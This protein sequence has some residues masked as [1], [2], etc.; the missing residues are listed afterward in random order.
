MQNGKLFLIQLRSNEQKR[1]SG[2]YSFNVM[3]QVP[4]RA[5]RETD[6]MTT[7][8]TSMPK[9]TS[10]KAQV[11]I[12]GIIRHVVKPGKTGIFTPVPEPLNDET[13]LQVVLRDD[14]VDLWKFTNIPIGKISTDRNLAVYSNIDGASFIVLDEVDGKML[15]YGKGRETHLTVETK[16]TVKIVFMPAIVGG[17]KPVVLKPPPDFTG[18]KPDKDKFAIGIYLP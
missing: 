10:I 17:D 3:L 7:I 18:I 1:I 2:T 16:N 11:R 6:G 4:S 15:G 14:E 5:T 12:V 9:E 13:Y 8:W